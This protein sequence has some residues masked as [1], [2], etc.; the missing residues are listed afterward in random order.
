MKKIVLVLLLCLV[1]TALCACSSGAAPAASSSGSSA[2][3]DD[4]QNPV[5]N[6]IGNYVCDRANILIETDGTDGAKAT[7]SWGGGAYDTATW[8]MSGAFDT[9]TLTFTYK[10]CVR[11]D[12]HY[13]QNGDVEKE[14]QIYTD[15]TGS[16][17]FSEDGGLSLT[18]QD[19]MEH[20]ADGMTFKYAN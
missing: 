5:M 6:F 17:V 7:V 15:G 13:A 3:A 16:M 19:D 20:Q 18:W 2:E 4:G 8:T 12:V 10:D 9:D 14:D 11:T 1:L